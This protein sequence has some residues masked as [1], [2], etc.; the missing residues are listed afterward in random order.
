MNVKRARP[1]RVTVT[2]GRCPLG[3]LPTQ[4]PGGRLKPAFLQ[5]VCLFPITKDAVTPDS[6]C[7]YDNPPFEDPEKKIS[8]T[9]RIDAALANNLDLRRSCGK[10]L[11]A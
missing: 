1:R 7:D 5:T 9:F 11:L 2:G 6:V 3:Q 4:P 10:Q 8:A